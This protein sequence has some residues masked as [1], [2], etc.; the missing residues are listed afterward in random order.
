MVIDL[1]RIAK[2]ETAK[3]IYFLNGNSISTK[4]L[5]VKFYVVLKRYHIKGGMEV[6]KMA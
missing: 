6:Q 2:I 5:P 1:H 3:Y 4:I